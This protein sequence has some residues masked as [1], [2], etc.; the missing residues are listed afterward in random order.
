MCSLPGFLVFTSVL[1]F[2]NKE[3]PKVAALGSSKTN[4][5]LALATSTKDDS[6]RSYIGSK[7]TPQ[8]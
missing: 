4:E 6:I 5:V 2:E 7:A 3:D 1:D 8:K